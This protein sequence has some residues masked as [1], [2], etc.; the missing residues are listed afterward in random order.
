[1]RCIFCL[2]EREPSAEHVFPDAIG[3][4]LV[5]DRV[6]KPCN[7]WLG[8][9]ADARL[10]DHM[11]VL[12][13]RHLLQLPN[14]DGKT[15]GF[16]DI[17]TIG[18]LAND[19]DQRI[20]LVRDADGKVVPKL[21]YKA[22]RTRLDDG[23]ENIQITVDASEIDALPKI[24]A[25][26]RKRENL[27]PLSQIELQAQ[28]DAAIAQMGTTHQPVVTYHPA[29]D[30]VSYRKALYK[31]VYELAWLWLGD[32]YLD[33][34]LAIRLRSIIFES[35]DDDGLKGSIQL[36]DEATGTFLL[37]KSEPDAHIGLAQRAGPSVLVAVRV[38]DAI[39]AFVVV[40][41]HAD[42]YP[43]FAEGMFFQCDPKF[44]TERRSTIAEEIG[45]MAQE[46]RARTET[47]IIRAR[48]N[49]G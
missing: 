32:A 9:N 41:E 39:S 3:G 46:A 42:H 21:M 18:T 28:V 17:F 13:R 14:R 12:M 24:I 6:C 30:L 4:T 27:P 26:M 1:M 5:I 33:D 11:S 23:S 40:T 37:W 25:R 19:P 29:L 44:G 49:Q 43:A 47:E 35:A 2:N 45:R 34:P 8:A 20:K 48:R 10:T 15:I 22:S 31:I 36:G 7:D 38:F 16:E